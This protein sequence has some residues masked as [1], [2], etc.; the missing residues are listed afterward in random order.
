MN[1]FAD[2]LRKYGVLIAGLIFMIALLWSNAHAGEQGDKYWS[3]TDVTEVQGNTSGATAVFYGFPRDSNSQVVVKYV[4]VTG[5]NTADNLD[6]YQGKTSTMTTLTVAFNYTMSASM[7]TADSSGV[8]TGD[9]FVVDDGAG[10]IFWSQ[11]ATTSGTTGITSDSALY[12][13]DSGVTFAIGSRVYEMEKISEL[14]VGNAS[15]AKSNADAVF[16]TSKGLPALFVI[17]G[18][19]S[20]TYINGITVTYE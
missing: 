4:D 17:E 1:T 3:G 7:T 6:V 10:N 18:A 5:G 2:K 13:G 19:A 11:V 16:A 12:G 9:F 20:G 8:T 15:V 14:H